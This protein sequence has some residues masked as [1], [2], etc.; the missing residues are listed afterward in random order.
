M[1]GSPRPK[2]EEPNQEAPRRHV[3]WP[4][5]EERPISADE[6]DAMQRGGNPYRKE[7]LHDQSLR[8]S[9]ERKNRI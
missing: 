9:G 6:W 3:D 2:S 4:P 1:E 7:T 8:E 5:A